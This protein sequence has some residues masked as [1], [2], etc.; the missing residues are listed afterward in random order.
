MWD[1]G[2]RGAPI[3]R[4][5]LHKSERLAWQ[6]VV[7]SPVPSL[8][9]ISFTK[10]VSPEATLT[11]LA[12][13]VPGITT[14]AEVEGLLEAGEGNGPLWNDLFEYEPAVRSDKVPAGTQVIQDNELLRA[15]RAGR[16]DRHLLLW[17][18]LVMAEPRLEAIV[19][20]VLTDS[21]GHLKVS[22]VNADRL[23]SVLQSRA[24]ANPKLPSGRKPTTNILSLLS[25]CQLI[26]PRRV[27]GTIVG[28]DRF[29]PTR[30][31]AQ[32]V[33]TLVGERL[34]AQGILA[35]PSGTI[36]LAI[37]IGANTWL[38]L[39]R[40]EFVAALAPAPASTQS[41]STRG[42]I[43]DDL[44]ELATQLRRKK[45]VVLQGPPGAGK[46]FVARK[47]VGWATANRSEDSRVQ[48]II[49]G[50]PLNERDAQGIAGE[51]VRRGLP[52]VWDIVQFHPG[53][54]YTDF[55]RA[56]VAQPH[57][58]GVTFVAQH[59]IFSLMCS[60]GNELARLGSTAELILILDE[61]NRGDIPNIF[62]ELLYALEY[63]DEAVATPY[64]ID[65]DAS[66][67]VP[68]RL[69][70]LGTMN[71]A[72]RSIAV[73]DYALRRRFV[74]LNVAATDTPINNYAFDNEETRSAALFLAALTRQAL[75]EAPSGLKIG[76]SYFL[77]SPDGVATSLEV[78][79]ARFVYEVLPL[80]TEYEMEGEVDSAAI[81]QLHGNL[82]LSTNSTQSANATALATYL[83]E[84]PWREGNTGSG[85][86]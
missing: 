85:G 23:E 86:E 38:N 41:Q 15:V 16:A 49:D 70:I 82:T 7:V 25:G 26:E 62:G 46:T 9:S 76:P 81:E 54:D 56:L 40:D 10:F 83:T 1:T 35:V 13:L 18:A 77:A 31:A 74:F 80:L 78:L 63:R 58:Q 57:G 53:Y 75:S 6:A 45:Q 37:S 24:A 68:A 19:R 8:G 2:R 5:H 59:R 66:L 4:S 11:K 42:P 21:D 51:I 12:Q 61:I 43:P 64:A 79:S 71:T 33:V 32:G 17:A 52:A 34:A 65:G 29:L 73:I 44:V 3:N 22:E 84:S 67:T 36:D 28:V 72:D 47:Y 69:Q 50:L 60:V 39:S 14:A 55:V 20:E 48:G 27:G 30:F